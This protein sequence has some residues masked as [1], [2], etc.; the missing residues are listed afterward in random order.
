[1]VRF[2]SNRSEGRRQGFRFCESILRK[3]KMIISSRFIPIRSQ[4]YTCT[5]Q[6]ERTSLD[7]FAKSNISPRAPRKITTKD[8][9]DKTITALIDVLVID[10]EVHLFLIVF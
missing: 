7:F 1:M 3:G 2:D 5:S 4:H 9:K 10:T 8:R 6:V